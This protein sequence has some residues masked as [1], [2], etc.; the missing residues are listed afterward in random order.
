[1]NLD[2][3]SILKT[4]EVVAPLIGAPHLS[5]EIKRAEALVPLID[6]SFNGG[7]KPSQKSNTS[8]D[9]ARALQAFGLVGENAPA[10]IKAIEKN[11]FPEA[12]ALAAGLNSG[13][14]DDAKTVI[15]GATKGKF[16]TNE[17][18]A[19]G[20]LGGKVF[21]NPDLESKAE[22]AS[23]VAGTNF[24]KLTINQGLGLASSFGA[25]F[26]N[27]D[28]AYGAQAAQQAINLTK[29]PFTLASA[30]SVAGLANTLVGWFAPNNKELQNVTNIASKVATFATNPILGVASLILDFLGG[31]GPKPDR[32]GQITYHNAAF[33]K[34]GRSFTVTQAHNNQISITE[35]NR[36]T[37]KLPESALT[38]PSKARD[39]L[40]P[41]E[42][43]RLGDEIVN[44]KGDARVRFDAQ[45]G[46]VSQ[47]KKS[48]GQWETVWRANTGATAPMPGSI[49]MINQ[50]TGKLS[51][52]TPAK[53]TG[54]F[55]ES[56]TS[57][58]SYKSKAKDAKADPR[59]GMLHIPASGAKE[60]EI[61]LQRPDGTPEWDIVKFTAAF[62]GGFLGIGSYKRD[63]DVG[64]PVAQEGSVPKKLDSK[65]NGKEA[66]FFDRPDQAMSLGQL[67]DGRVAIKFKTEGGDNWAYLEDPASGNFQLMTLNALGNKLNSEMSQD[68]EQTQNKN[69][70][71]KIARNYYAN[72][73]QK[74][75]KNTKK[76]LATQL[77]QTY[78][79]NHLL[80]SSRIPP[81][82]PRQEGVSYQRIMRAPTFTISGGSS[83][84]HKVEV[85]R[86]IARG[87]SLP[88]SIPRLA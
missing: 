75:R 44:P 42:G 38:G 45:L 85:A 65:L 21:N 74:Y 77:K 56:W 13:N 31:L 34:N 82:S 63:L 6:R 18:K 59:Q 54:S 66:G 4:A 67:P 14:I 61:A 36:K 7:S 17:I 32:Y 33:S 39:T 12:I 88:S 52:F 40:M 29:A 20:S 41:G 8:Q 19:L 35:D 72:L 62:K 49:A 70:F 5:R 46:L 3:K 23:R 37:V 30:G 73:A 80:L 51:V 11:N 47:Q 60:F 57:N 43:L 48:D 28:I 15:N 53:K 58:Q 69:S 86:V 55:V 27:R 22:L 87:P 71:E 9:V 76:Q 64:A 78:L 26:N 24:N 79:P 81:S 16:G 83:S 2:L 25:A 50:E 84:N 68:A 1:M 10:A